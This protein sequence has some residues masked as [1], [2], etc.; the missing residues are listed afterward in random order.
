MLSQICQFITDYSK[1]CFNGTSVEFA[2]KCHVIENNNKTATYI[3]RT[4]I[5]S[6]SICHR[7][8]LQ[9]TMCLKNNCTSGLGYLQTAY[10]LVC[11]QNLFLNSP[12]EFLAILLPW[13]SCIKTRCF[14]SVL[15]VCNS[16]ENKSFCSI[17]CLLLVLMQETFKYIE[18]NLI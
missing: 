16:T 7:S 5:S 15:Q 2:N 17:V 11:L 8:A 12:L 3:S 18:I 14:H 6:G 4:S 9:T 13:Q 1:I 10:K